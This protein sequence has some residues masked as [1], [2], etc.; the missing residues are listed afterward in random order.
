[1]TLDAAAGRLV[2][3]ARLVLAFALGWAGHVYY[4]AFA[5]GRF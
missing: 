1:M 3:V 4:A 2:P 5:A